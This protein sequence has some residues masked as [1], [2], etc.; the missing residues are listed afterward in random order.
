MQ[1]HRSSCG[2]HLGL[3]CVGYKFLLIGVNVCVWVWVCVCVCVGVC[4][5]VCVCWS[6]CVVL[7]CG[8]MLLC[9]WVCVCVCGGVSIS[10]CLYEVLGTCYI[11]SKETIMLNVINLFRY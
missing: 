2:A 7:L 9:V 6:V 11:T 10:A 8:C 5:C 1:F 4:V 3:C